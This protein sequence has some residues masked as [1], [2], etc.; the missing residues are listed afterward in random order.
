MSQMPPLYDARG[1]LIKREEPS[2]EGPGSSTETPT[3]NPSTAQPP[4]NRARR[5]WPAWARGWKL[6]VEISAIVALFATY[7]A[8]R[9][10][11]SVTSFVGTG[12]DGT[13][14]VKATVTDT[15]TSPIKNVSVQ[16][17]TNKVIFENRFT[18]EFDKFISVDEYSVGDMKAGESFTANCTFAWSIWENSD[19][20]G[21]LV[22]GY[23]TVM[24]P[25][26]GITYRYEN[27]TPVVTGK[28]PTA[29]TFGFDDAIRY[30]NRRLTGV[31]GNFIVRYKWRFSPFRQTKTIHM[32]ESPGPEDG[33]KWRVAPASE[34]VIPDPPPHDDGWKM[35]AKSNSAQFGLT[36][37]GGN[38]PL[39]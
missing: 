37:K 4:P 31:D 7:Y 13:Y 25:N 2:L 36:L 35:T 21:V 15:G 23:P 32:I 39:P 14:G 24:K 29:I 11:L 3:K 27:G 38:Y 10:I 33:I 34:S 30:H 22:L 1:N 18:L 5:I 20:Q 16:C 9:P 6:G 17:V 26:V 28:W 19:R 8:L 12:I